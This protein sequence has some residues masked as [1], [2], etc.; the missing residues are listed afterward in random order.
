[1][2]DIKRGG[3][4]IPA[5]AMASGRFVLRINPGLHLALRR[6]AASLGI[7]LNDYCVRRLSAVP[8]SGSGSIL[9]QASEVVARAA[10]QFGS[11]LAGIVVHGS[12][13]RGE[14]VDGSDVDILVILDGSVPLTRALYRSWDSSDLLIEGRPV[15]AHFVHLPRPGQSVAGF[16]AEISIEG[17]VLFERG[18]E[19]SA[20]LAGIRRE[21]AAGRLVRRVVHGQ[22][23]WTEV[24]PEEVG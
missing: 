22:P 6:S 18:M 15:E 21:I 17:L 11:A 13:L 24:P 16:W 23:Y 14:A 19:I 5:M 8:G 3:G 1:M 4:E 10:E 2:A 12:W 20:A 9:D 7:S